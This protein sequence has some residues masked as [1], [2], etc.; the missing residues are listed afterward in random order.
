MG[1][2][3]GSQV[4]HTSFYQSSSLFVTW[5]SFAYFVQTGFQNYRSCGLCFCLWLSILK[6]LHE[7]WCSEMQGGK[8]RWNCPYVLWVWNVCLY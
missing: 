7:I 5:D 3:D 2:A 8:R 4:S 6:S 1:C